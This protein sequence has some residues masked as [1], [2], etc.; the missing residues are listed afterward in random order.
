MLYLFMS[1][2]IQEE[3]TLPKI[4]QTGYI[5]N[6]CK[7]N[8]ISFLIWWNFFLFSLNKSLD[9]TARDKTFASSVLCNQLHIMHF[10]MFGQNY[11]AYLWLL[12][13][14]IAILEDLWEGNIWNLSIFIKDFINSLSCSLVFRQYFCII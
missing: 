12:V 8:V 1:L 9:W 5:W 4:G 11:Q 6:Q 10:S 3:I 7:I 13:A 2:T 14:W